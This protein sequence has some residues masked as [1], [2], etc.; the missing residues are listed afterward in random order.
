[1]AVPLDNIQHLLSLPLYLSIY[2]CY[3]FW[4]RY[5][6]SVSHLSHVPI[7]HFFLL[8][9]KHH[10]LNIVYCTLQHSHKQMSG[11]CKRLLMYTAKLSYQRHILYYYMSIV[12]YCTTNVMHWTAKDVFVV[13]EKQYA[14]PERDYF[15]IT[16]RKENL[17]FFG[18]TPPQVY[19]S[20][21]W[22]EKKHWSDWLC[23]SMTNKLNAS[24]LLQ[25]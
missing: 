14:N 8:N 17:P 9:Y 23:T 13:H 5:H 24:F 4:S 18:T 3:L 16:K 6:F 25:M 11:H 19:H 21:P 2:I 22:W 20:Q 1:M 12:W 7:K 10:I 15:C